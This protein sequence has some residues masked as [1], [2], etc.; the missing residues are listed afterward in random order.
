MPK[1]PKVE[2]FYRFKKKQGMYLYPIADLLFCMFN[3]AEV[4]TKDGA[5]R[6]HNFRHFRQFRHFRHLHQSKPKPL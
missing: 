3:I 2:E 1:V 5:K 4:Y 6:H